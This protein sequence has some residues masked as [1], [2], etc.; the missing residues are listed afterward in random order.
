MSLLQAVQSNYEPGRQLLATFGALAEMNNRKRSLDLAAQKQQQDQI[1]QA[2]MLDLKER[3]FPLEMLEKS[4]QI[5]HTQ[6]LTK[7]QTA[8][9]E[10]KVKA[11]AD[12][13]T[14]ADK[15]TTY[16]SDQGDL[17]TR[18]GS[19]DDEVRMKAYADLGEIETDFAASPSPEV[20]AGIKALYSQYQ[21]A[22]RESRYK[23]GADAT[24]ADKERY[25]K[26]QEEKEA[27]LKAKDEK[28]LRGNEHFDLYPTEYPTDK[29]TGKPDTSKEP[30]RDTSQKPTTIS[31]NQIR[32]TLGRAHV[33]IRGVED[34]PSKW[35]PEAKEAWDAAGKLQTL[36]RQVPGISQARFKQW[37]DEGIE[38]VEKN[39]LPTKGE[40]AAVAPEALMPT[41]PAP[42]TKS[43][44]EILRG[45]GVREE[46]LQKLRK[47]TSA[48]GFGGFG[49]VA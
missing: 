10:V 6:A 28:S 9:A 49:P 32:E 26:L 11:S 13:N 33:L 25:R 31:E 46:A 24:A 29:K 48:I 2:A 41:A 18:L 35:S 17:A 20:R 12:F 36:L 37:A 23:K 47:P 5:Q 1:Y 45:A 30:E 39:A 8:A 22:E 4:A 27:R 19:S 15:L 34:Q 3:M 40:P 21:F 38:R 44:E 16:S 43:L 42:A 7:L 14:F